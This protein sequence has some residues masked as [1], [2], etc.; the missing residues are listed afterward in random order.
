MQL[1]VLELKSFYASPLGSAAR[2]VIGS[3]VRQHWGRVPG[4]TIAGIGYASPFIGAYRIEAARVLAL[5]PAAQGALVWPQAGSV[6]TVMVEEHALP[7]PDNSI[8]RILVVHCLEIAE[9]SRPLLRELWRV[10]APEGRVLLVVPNRNGIWSRREATPFGHGQPYSRRQLQTLL[11]DS[12][13][14]PLKWSSGLHVPPLNLKSVA[15]FA[16]VFERIGARFWPRLAGVLLVEA[17]KEVE[18]ILPAGSGARRIG[19]LA[20]AD[21]TAERGTTAAPS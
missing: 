7:L 3:A 16:P 9:Q 6:N 4:Q 11:T 19:R 15:R 21:N 8:D 20:T 2:R 5:M 1:D 13:F 12:L 18:A 17:T 10:L 14:T